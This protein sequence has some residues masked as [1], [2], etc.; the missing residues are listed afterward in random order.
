MGKRMKAALSADFTYRMVGR[1]KQILG[2]FK[3]QISKVLGDGKRS[4]V[5]EKLTDVVWRKRDV[6]GYILKRNVF[7]E[8][9]VEIEQ[10]SLYLRFLVCF[11]AEFR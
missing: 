1:I 9:F 7:F 8:I 6:I 3:A 11:L 4:F 10:N 2:I 5:V